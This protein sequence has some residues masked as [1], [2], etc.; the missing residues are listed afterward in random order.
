MPAIPVDGATFRPGE[1]SCRIR[2]AKDSTTSSR[3]PRI[4]G[5]LLLGA[6]SG[7]T[8]RPGGDAAACPRDRASSDNFVILAI[9]RSFCAPRVTTI[10]R[11]RPP[12]HR[13][14][15]NG[16]LHLRLPVAGEDDDIDRVARAVDLM[17][18]EDRAPS[19]P[20]QKRRATTSPMISAA[21]SP[22]PR[23]KIERSSSTT[24]RESSNRARPWR[25]PSPKS[26]QC[27]RR[28][29]HLAIS[30]GRTCR[31]G[32]AAPGIRS[33][34]GL[35]PGPRSLRAART[36]EVRLDGSS[37]PTGRARARGRGSHA[38]SHLESRRQC[39]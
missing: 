28:F 29:S 25:P 33:R 26:K 5:A 1:I 7:R 4:D 21:P 13:E 3:A 38:R 6:A 10:F 27:R 32:E 15:M 14:I 34:R 37:T 16:T 31:A 23:A 8:D 9:R 11:A 36:I 24:R 18:D 22:S 39:D 35:C 12:R 20:P 19:R 30:A 17:L 2:W